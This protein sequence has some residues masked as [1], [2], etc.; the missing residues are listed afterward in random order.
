MDRLTDETGLRRPRPVLAV[1]ASTA[2]RGS[3]ARNLRPC[4]ARR[5]APVHAA[6]DPA[7]LDAEPRCTQ[8]A[9]VPRSFRAAVPEDAPVLAALFHAAVHALPDALYG[10]GEREA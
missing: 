10:P 6:C 1:A 7:V 3:D 2:T 9:A 4:G 8:P 5:G